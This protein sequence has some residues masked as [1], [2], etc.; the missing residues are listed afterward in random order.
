[1]SDETAAV[2][3]MDYLAVDELLDLQRPLS[4]GPEHDE[5][6]FIV[7]HQVYELWFKQTLHEIDAAQR[8]LETGSG[9]DA[10]ASLNRIKAILSVCIQQI[11]VLLTMTPLNFD[12]FRDRLQTASGFQ[13]A[14]FRELEAALGRRDAN[15]AQHLLPSGRQRVMARVH[16]RSLWESMLVFIERCGY[17]IPAEVLE[18]DV[19]SPYVPSPEVRSVLLTMHTDHHEATH[20]CEQ[21]LDIEVSLREWRFRHVMMVERTIGT[22]SGT[23]G[24]SGSGY[25]MSTLSAPRIFPEL[26]DVRADF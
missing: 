4:E 18:R 14:Q 3:Y 8:S 6:L 9:F 19:T 20:L 11:D 1:M 25:L 24:S 12:A 21:L 22:K 26:W 7:I 10:Y 13:S 2:T 17:P 15:F 5:M 23:G 16:R